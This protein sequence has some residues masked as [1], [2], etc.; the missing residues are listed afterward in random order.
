MALILSRD[1]ITGPLKTV[2][3]PSG[4]MTDTLLLHGMQTSEYYHVS[5]YGM[6]VAVITRVMCAAFAALPFHPHTPSWHR[7]DTGQ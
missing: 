6:H 3:Q 1:W 4:E 5:L 2:G 7:H